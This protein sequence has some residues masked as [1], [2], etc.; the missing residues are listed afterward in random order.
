[1]NS[2]GGGV[3]AGTRA[4]ARTSPKSRLREPGV[5]EPGLL[6]ASSLCA[7]TPSGVKSL[8]SLLGAV[9]PRKRFLQQADILE[10]SK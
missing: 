8:S 6:G 5:A 7:I 4:G 2:K 10:Q 9:E 3:E 1:M